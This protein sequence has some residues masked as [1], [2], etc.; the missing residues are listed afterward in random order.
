MKKYF[1]S[2]LSILLFA[3]TYAGV[4]PVTNPAPEKGNLIVRDTLSLETSSGKI[5]MGRSCFDNHSEMNLEST[6]FLN[7]E[8]YHEAERKGVLSDEVIV[9]LKRDENCS[10]THFSVEKKGQL[11]S[12]NQLAKQ[13]CTELIENVDWELLKSEH[14]TTINCENIVIPLSVQFF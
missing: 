10:V 4:D 5:E 3:S 1:T 2:V 7:T 8:V 13:F 12:M 9:S 14:C 6:L 11:E